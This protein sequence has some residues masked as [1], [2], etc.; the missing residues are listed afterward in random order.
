MIAALIINV[1][2]SIAVC[3]LL[4]A[5]MLLGFRLAQLDEGGDEQPVR[6]RGPSPPTPPPGSHGRARPRSTTRHSER[7]HTAVPL[8]ERAVELVGAAGLART[9]RNR[10]PDRWPGTRRSSCQRVTPVMAHRWSRVNL[11]RQFRRSREFPA[12]LRRR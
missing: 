6:V 5:V 7:P 12:P 1:G 11:K 4:A 3:A 10:V 8:H 2:M 9:A